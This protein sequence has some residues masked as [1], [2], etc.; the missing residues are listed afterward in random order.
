MNR[1]ETN[2]TFGSLVCVVLGLVFSAAVLRAAVTGTILGRVTDPS[3][4]AIPGAT[5]TLRNPNTGFART[6]TTDATGS[7]EFLLVPIGDGYTVQVAK[8]GFETGV[9]SGI[10]LLVNESHSVDVH[11]RLGAVTQ[12]VNVSGALVQVQTVNTQLGDVIGDQKME[13]LP[14]NGRSFLDLLGLQAGVAPTS[15]GTMGSYGP[16]SVEGEFFNG[17][18][19]VSGSREDTNSFIVNGGD[20][21][22]SMENGA[23]VDP[24]LDAIEEFRVLTSSFDAE[25]GR[26]SGGI[27]N[28]VTKSGTN[29]FH[30]DLFEFL[31]NEKLDSRNFFNYNQTN[32]ETGQELPGTAIGEYDRNQF[33]GTLGGPILKNRLFFFGGYQGTR[34]VVG[35]SSGVIDVPSLAERNGDFSDVG[36]TGYAPLTGI[37]HGCT[38]SNDN[39][40]CMN[41]VL[42][43]E[44]GY[45]VTN[46]EP[47]YTPGCTSTAN[48]VFPGA[49]IPQGAFSSAA[50]GTMKFIPLPTGIANG[51]PFFSTTAYKEPLRDDKFDARIDYNGGKTGNWSV[52]YHFDDSYVINPYEG[53]NVPGFA[54]GNPSRAQ[55]VNLGNT[56]TFG[57]NK[58]NEWRLNYTRLSLAYGE[59]TTPGE[60]PSNYGFVAGGLG[61][62][63]AAPSWLAPPI[64]FLNQLG[65]TLS[66]QEP[67]WQANNT[68][69][70]KDDFSM[71]AGKHTLKFGGDFEDFELNEYYLPRPNGNFS[72]AGSETGND[73]ADYLIGTPSVY[74]QM[75][76]PFMDARSKYLGLYAQDSYRLMP[77]LTLN[78]GLRWEFAQPWSDTQG[79]FQAWVPGQQSIIYPDSPTGWD[80]PGDPGVPSSLAP[81]RYDNFSPRIGIAYSPGSTSGL[82]AKLFGGPHM[83]SI[84][85]SFGIFHTAFA[86]YQNA[87]EAGDP[88]F[89]DEFTSSV[90]VYFAEPYEGRQ[91]TNQ[92]QPFPYVPAKKG[93]TGPADLALWA[94]FQPIGGTAGAFA[95]N[96]VLPYQ[97]TTNFSI[98]R[99]LG[100]ST[101]LTLSYV[102]TFGHHLLE[103]TMPNP[104]NRALCL[105]IRQVLG[106]ANGCGPYGEEAIYHYPDGQTIYGT[107]PYSV[108]SGRELNHNP[109]E[110]DFGDVTLISTI[111][112][113]T[114]NAL[115]VTV[116]KRAGPLQFLAAYTWSKSLDEGSCIYCAIGTLNPYN[117]S[118]SEGLSTFDLTDNFTVSYAYNLPFQKLAH[119]ASGL[120]HKLL[121]GWQI[122]GI[123]RFATGFPVI[124]GETGDQSLCDGCTEEPDYN[125]QPLQFYNPRPSASHQY[126]STS[127]FSTTALGA[128]GTANVASFHGPGFNEWDMSLHKMTHVTEGTSIEFRLE[129]FNVFNHTQFTS[130]GGALGSAVFGDVT[131]A[132]DPRIGQAALKFNF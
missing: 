2:R 55:Q 80:F 63:P 128:L 33:G 8:E 106:P 71:I 56:R 75:S 69:Q 126:F 17:T 84:R 22:D 85:A 67:Y 112:N 57:A 121:D 62:L 81:T 61:I 38:A 4:A 98:E 113:S 70:A 6:M 129:F 52:Y 91:G 25:Y 115:E 44:L 32:P 118:L 34:Q 125:G 29:A 49:V 105:Q 31:R 74:S 90:P 19:S 43:Q 107:E 109:P 10:T 78:Y 42:T 77:N 114:Y 47:Y 92:T 104:G 64:M 7:F 111:G 12:V 100:R 3:G 76:I 89:A 66:N 11:L 45:P 46:G 96:N 9:Q 86:Q 72:F 83:T 35:V 23:A 54:G 82:A 51:T 123:T 65:I 95:T 122:T 15:T 41:D 87:Y 48:C 27:V 119:S 37:V 24:V 36:T 53:A 20:V 14:L 116:S 117:N 18:L 68:Y 59:P 79:R 99:Q 94:A 120:A 21:N 13:T 73:F 5:V 60:P 127:Q 30:G 103:N 124:I 93:A 28:V 108:T 132:R 40:H 130:P 88:P 102:G 39:G 50:V 1:S 26:F 58:V 131:S 97:E 110:L 101:I 16:N